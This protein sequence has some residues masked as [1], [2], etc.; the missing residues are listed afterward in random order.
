MYQKAIQE[1]QEHCRECRIG[2]AIDLLMEFVPGSDLPG[3]EPAKPKQTRAKP[4]KAD[5]SRSE[6]D[7]SVST[8]IKPNP[9]RTEK[10]CNKCH[11]VKPLSEFTPNKACLDGHVGTCRT[12]ERE[13]VRK[14]QGKASPP[15]AKSDKPHACKVCG[16]RFHSIDTLTE[17]T[18]LRHS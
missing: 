7:Q 14:Q 11:T 9:N 10:P 1:L 4:I 17:H 13:R 2:Q 16:V 8:R 3:P 5:P 12:C 15:P 6:P 18:K